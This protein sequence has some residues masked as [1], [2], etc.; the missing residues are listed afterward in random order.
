MRSTPAVIILGSIVAAGALMWPALYNGQPF[1]FPDTTA[2]IRAPDAALQKLT[3]LSSPWTQLEDDGSAANAQAPPGEVP[4]PPSVSSIKDKTVLSGRSVYYGAL[5]YLGDR[6]GHF[7]FTVLVQAVLLMLAMGL[8]LKAFGVRWPR[9][10]IA[11]VAVGV[12]TLGLVLRELA[13]AGSVCGGDIAG[14]RE[15]DR[16]A[17]LAAAST[18]VCG[19]R[20]W[21]FRWYRIHP[22]Y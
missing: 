1:F 21:Y 13:D 5:L 8:F 2:Y 7:W 10:A 3:G 22:M 20:C 6:F 14:V 18:T 11:G 16:C 19:S 9:L 4:A 12:L 17:F 15:S